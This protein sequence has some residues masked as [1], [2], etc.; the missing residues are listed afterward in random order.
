M[1]E[2]EV[3]ATI[4]EMLCDRLGIEP[5]VLE[6]DTVLFGDGIG[7]DSIDSLEIISAIDEEYG[8]QMTGVGKEHFRNIDALAAYVMANA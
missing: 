1:N 7:L 3:K 2:N 6:Y 4:K 8:V 5:D